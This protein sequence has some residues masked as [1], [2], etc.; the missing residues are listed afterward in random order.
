MYLFIFRP[1]YFFIIILFFNR[2]GIK[3]CMEITAFDAVKNIL[4]PIKSDAKDAYLLTVW[5]KCETYNQLLAHYRTWTLPRCFK[6]FIIFLNFARPLNRHLFYLNAAHFSVVAFI[7]PSKLFKSV[8]LH[9]VKGLK[10]LEQGALLWASRAA[11]LEQE[12]EPLSF[13]WAHKGERTVSH[14]PT[15]GLC[16]YFLGGRG[17][18]GRSWTELTH[19]LW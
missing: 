10:P 9:D 18:F 15:A 4:Q 19:R 13:S 6:H 7:F 8:S 12:L 11:C 5:H 17:I 1:I 2:V 14:I 3:V 16:A